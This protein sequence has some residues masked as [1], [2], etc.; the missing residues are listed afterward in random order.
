MKSARLPWPRN[1]TGRQ[2]EQGKFKQN[3]DVFL[4][5]VTESLLGGKYFTKCAEFEYPSSL[6]SFSLTTGSILSGI[7]WNFL[8]FPGIR[9]S[10]HGLVIIFSK[11]YIHP[12]YVPKRF[13]LALSFEKISKIFE[14]KVE[15]EG[16]VDGG[17]LVRWGDLDNFFIGITF[18][19]MSSLIF[20]LL[21]WDFYR[22]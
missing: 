3:Y 11:I 2:D 7:S 13:F 10:L 6:F 14:G 12:S 17:D 20:K 22:V 1:L 8:D 9:L 18:Q 5:R 4:E 19:A 21:Q 16:T 15:M